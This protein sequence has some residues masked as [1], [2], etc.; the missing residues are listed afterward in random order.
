[1]IT[2]KKTSAVPYQT[3]VTHLTRQTLLMINALATRNIK[4]SRPPA[5]EN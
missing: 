5:V 2:S 3:L 4:A 1:M